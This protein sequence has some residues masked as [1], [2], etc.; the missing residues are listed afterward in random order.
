MAS[1]ILAGDQLNFTR[2]GIASVDE[3]K[4]ILAD[5]LR[6]EIKP[7]DLPKSITSSPELMTGRH[8]LRP[9]QK[10]LCCPS[11]TAVPDYNKFD[12]S[13]LYTLIRNLCPQLKP[14]Q[15]WGKTPS[16]TDLQVGDDIERLRVFRNEM[17][18]HLDSSS[19][20]DVVFTA[21][22][23]N[24]EQIFQ[25]MQTFLK[26]K[27]ISVDYGKKL[28]TIEKSD[29]GF[30]DMEKYKI[31]LEG[32]LHIVKE[33]DVNGGLSITIHGNDEIFFGEKTYFEAVLDRCSPSNNWPIMW[34]KIQGNITE[35][36][37]TS[38]EK[39]RG[40][41][42]RCLVISN[43][44][45]EDEGEYR[46]VISRENNGTHMKIPS[47]S[48]Q[49]TVNGDLPA[50]TMPKE[51]EVPYGSV[52]VFEPV[53][54]AC[55]PPECVEWQKSKY[56]D[57][58]SEKF[59]IIDFTSPKY[60]GSSLDPTDS[61]L[62]IN[63]TTFE[64][65]LFYRLVVKNRVGKSSCSTFLNIVGTPPN[66]I[67]NHDTDFLE[68]S[69]TF[70][71]KVLCDSSHPLTG[72]VWTKGNHEIDILS[73]EGKYTGGE[74]GNP[75]LKIT[76]VNA[77]DAGIYQC[78]ASNYVGTTQSEQVTLAE[79]SVKLLM[80]EKDVENG[81]FKLQA[82]IKSIPDAFKVE[83]KA[84]MNPD[85][86]FR[87]INLH[88]ESYKGTTTTLPNPLLVVNEYS[89]KNLETYRIEVTNF[90]GIKVVTSQ[91]VLEE[92]RLTEENAN[93]CLNGLS[94]AIY[95]DKGAKIRFNNLRLSLIKGITK[96]EMS[97]LKDSLK[98]IV[99][100]DKETLNSLNSITDLVN[101]LKYKKIFTD[102]DVIT[103]Q[104]LMRIIERPDLEK[105]CIDYATSRKERLCY[106]QEEKHA[107]GCKR[108][109]LHVLDDIENFTEL[110][111]LIE[112]V[113]AIVECDPK[114]IEVVSILPETSF[115]IV[116]E[117]ER[118]LAQLLSRKTPN[119]LRI[120]ADYKIDKIYIDGDCIEITE[121]GNKDSLCGSTNKSIANERDTRDAE[122]EGRFEKEK[123]LGALNSFGTQV[124]HVLSGPCANLFRRILRKHILE[125]DFISMI[126]HSKIQL[127]PFLT[128]EQKRV[129]YPI[130]GSFSGSYKKL[131]LPLMYILFQRICLIKPHK[132]GWGRS[133][134]LS[135][136]SMAANID[137]IMEIHRD[138]CGN[139][140]VL[141]QSDFDRILKRILELLRNIED[142]L[143][144][145]RTETY[146]EKEDKKNNKG[147]LKRNE[148][149]SHLDSLGFL[150]HYEL[151]RVYFA[152]AK[153][154]VSL[155]FENS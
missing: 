32:I 8:K 83:W 115:F 12:V 25:R 59:K 67:M 82:A 110:D 104:Y 20:E 133:P 35:Q 78:S 11:P 138:Y 37:D 48:K 150:I 76:N 147:L 132:R 70:I 84:K 47:N 101:L 68:Q 5:I 73:S 95:K 148:E 22:W 113:A 69:V 72:L 105:K 80:R 19:V 33:N 3:I 42:S 155:I 154:E 126:Q 79:P 99:S 56:M 65:S 92:K 96:S 100:V 28:A 10:R 49:L 151:T 38:K 124:Q 71:C 142:G 36:L 58:N 62:I 109:K 123:N 140:V 117:V 55:P 129:L 50:L 30:E 89:S 16:L 127:L 137:R 118:K 107:D 18:A 23:Q 139:T 81:A 87:P 13:L 111:F 15:D 26:R 97:I 135:D 43:V 40:S 153:K 122:T 93:E 57:L 9:E 130:S 2:M 121:P 60:S 106:F 74:I 29:F 141:Q 44:S 152:V 14:T 45:K 63:D 120:L 91:E 75:S 64:D 54:Q 52:A 128:D 94:L 134:D 119:E 34:E 116:I 85:D 131:D 86:E 27:G 17:F 136:T 114:Y 90:L 61:K 66:V 125:E 112:T 21:K 31:I 145:S 146:G 6:C 53:I 77:S 39:Y 7:K 149:E 144:S 41:S 24:L 88:E 108:V 51:V 4:V 46:A 102:R 98:E 103:M 143:E 1:N